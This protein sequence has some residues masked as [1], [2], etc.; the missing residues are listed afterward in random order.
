[1]NKPTKIILALGLAGAAAVVVAGDRERK[2]DAAKVRTYAQIQDFA[3]RNESVIL[4]S[5][6]HSVS[7]YTVRVRYPVL[8]FIAREFRW[9]EE[10]PEPFRS[11]VTYNNFS[12]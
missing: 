7:T 5:R 10:Y 4:L 9:C 2:Y 12:D 1:M 8:R 6:N 3:E 11:E